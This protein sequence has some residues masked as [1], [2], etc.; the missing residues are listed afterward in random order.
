MPISQIKRGFAALSNAL[1]FMQSTLLSLRRDVGLARSETIAPSRLPGFSGDATVPFASNAITLANVNVNIGTFGNATHAAAVTVNAKGLTTAVSPVLVTPNWTSITNRPTTLTGLALTDA[2]DFMQSLMTTDED[3]MLYA[4]DGF[5]FTNN[6]GR[7][8]YYENSVANT[9]GWSFSRNS[10][11][12]AFSNGVATSYA[13]GVPRLTNTGLL[14]EEARLNQT[15][16]SN[17]F[18][19]WT[20]SDLAVVSN[21]TIAPDGTLTATRIV[22]NA[23]N[24]IHSVAIT[25]GTWADNVSYT[26]SVYAKAGERRYLW[27]ESRTK[28][29]SFPGGWFD[30][31][32]GTVLG[33]AGGATGA[34]LSVGN[35]WYRCSITANSQTGVSNANIV[36]GL[37]VSSSATGGSRT[38]LG[39]GVSGLF[40]W[41]AQT[42]TGDVATS[43]IITGNSTVTRSTEIA[44]LTRAASPQGTWVVHFRPTSVSAPGLR[45][46][47][48]G[49]VTTPFILS[50][51]GNV[52][53]HD[54]S[55][56][57]MS[58]NAIISNTLNKAA[59]TYTGSSVSTCLNGGTVATSSGG[60]NISA[61]T[62]FFIGGDSAGTTS[63]VLNGTIEK[64][65]FYPRAISST[66]LILHTELPL[67][68]MSLPAGVTYSRASVAT[69][70]TTSNTVVSFA[71]NVAPITDRG[72]LIEEAR[73]NRCANTNINPL[74]TT[75][76][77]LV[78]LGTGATLSIVNDAAELAAIGLTG[79][80][81]RLVAGSGIAFANMV[82]SGTLNLNPHVMQAYI[83][84]GTGA[85]RYSSGGTMQTFGTSSTYRRV[86][87]PAEAPNDLRTMMIQAD[88]GQT[89]FF[90]LN[91]LQEGTFPT[92]PIPTSG[93][94]VTRLLPTATV[95]VP[96][97]KTIARVTYGIANSVIDL[98]NLIP[99]STLDLVTNRP[100]V[101][102]GNEIKSLEWMA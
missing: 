79:N 55:S 13:S 65:L 96:P 34:I 58:N 83:R 54:V 99:G 63:A 33:V 43:P 87:K 5:N 62:Q 28:T 8:L 37:Q 14:M 61:M 77:A 2:E 67:S 46:L 26:A 42:E 3:G 1:T 16:R 93:A 25:N 49:A 52:Y 68:F 24:N 48:G 82:G 22:E 10:T 31:I 85:L 20:I 51:A 27:I 70:L 40:I 101:G 73:T 91:D 75:N 53:T 69:S 35:G 80:A 23:T 102:I 97:A 41:N 94:A 9:S 88:P 90:V 66:E 50:Q 12:I 15:L 6:T 45:R 47:I 44:S 60:A 11:A 59:M 17:Q 78:D 71:S 100:W 19:T 76:V 7:R 64:V 95:V 81:Y 98:Q 30:L 38:Y 57:A 39:D 92:S 29:P 86:I 21:A 36:L 74:N 72:M 84:G 18:S 89:V 56:L 32:D 4:L